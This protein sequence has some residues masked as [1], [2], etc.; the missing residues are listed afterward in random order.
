MELNFGTNI[1]YCHWKSGMM[2]A[3]MS[4]AILHIRELNGE[5]MEDFGVAFSANE[6]I[7]TQWM[8]SLWQNS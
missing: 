4:T 3:V 6:E 8:L 5:E 2:Q 1:Q 7:T